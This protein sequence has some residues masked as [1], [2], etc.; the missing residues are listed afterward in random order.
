MKIYRTTQFHYDP[1]TNTLSAEA[2]SLSPGAH[3]L[4][5]LHPFSDLVGCAIESMA[6][7]VILHFA[8]GI[9]EKS[10]EGEVLSWTLLPTV[11]TC[12]DQRRHNPKVLK[13]RVVIFND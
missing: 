7:G 1:K 9:V 3:P 12:R 8:L 5:K 6:T 11:E 13:M 4:A 10:P 2:S